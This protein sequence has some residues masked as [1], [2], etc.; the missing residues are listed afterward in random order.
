MYKYIIISILFIVCSR[1]YASEVNTDSTIMNI[2]IE[3]AIEIIKK[4]TFFQSYMEKE[5]GKGES[6]LINDTLYCPWVGATA[7]RKLYPDSCFWFIIYKN[8]YFQDCYKEFKKEPVIKLSEKYKNKNSNYIVYIGIMDSTSLNF[9]IF[10]NK[11][12]KYPKVYSIYIL[13][14]DKNNVLRF[15]SER[16]IAE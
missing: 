1:L 12:P 3:K 7:V 4:D 13:Y 11:N 2:R 8:N 9:L 15:H 14:D 6:F 16:Y 10:S 5:F